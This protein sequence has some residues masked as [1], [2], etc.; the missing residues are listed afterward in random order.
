MRFRAALN[1]FEE[2][3]H[4]AVVVFFGVFFLNIIVLQVFCG[5]A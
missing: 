5:L 4:F 2:M 3:F 1:I